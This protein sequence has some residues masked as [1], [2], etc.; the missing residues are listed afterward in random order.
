MKGHQKHSNLITEIISMLFLLLFVYAAVS[1]LLDYQKFKIQLV[2]SPLLATYASI[3]VWFIPT[4]ELIIA[5]I[6]LS[7]YKSL[8]LKLCLGLMIVFTIYIWYTLNYSDYIPCSC[9]GII[10]DLNWTEHLI[11]NLFW[12]VF[13]IIAISTNKGAKHTT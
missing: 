2:Q 7:K 8:G 6:L 4:L 11:F 5:M 12:I 9:G 1:K 10:S 13:A 3:L